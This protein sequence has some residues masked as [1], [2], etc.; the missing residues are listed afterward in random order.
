LLVGL[1]I[2]C[3]FGGG[4]TAQDGVLTT[5]AALN[6]YAAGERDIV[7]QYAP[8]RLPPLWTIADNLG[9]LPKP[10][11]LTATG[12]EE[13]P[14]VVAAFALEAARTLEDQSQANAC[15]LITATRVRWIA[16][17]A[18]SDF[19][20]RWFAAAIASLLRDGCP[21]DLEK[22][23]NVAINVFPTDAS[24]RLARL[25]AAEQRLTAAFDGGERP[26]PREL[27][28]AETRFKI[29]EAL[30]P[31]RAEAGLRW[32][33]INARLGQHA[34]AI[35]FAADAAASPDTRLRYLAHLF[36]GW[37]LAALGKLADADTEYAKAL[38]LVPGAQSATLARAAA[39]FRKRDAGRAD[40]IVSALISHRDPPADP[41]WTYAIGDGRNVDQLIADLRRVIR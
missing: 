1:S 30:P 9:H 3:T 17:D 5:A 33:R 14:R 18:K 2:L 31:S 10:I 12:F 28:D 24:F 20:R 7:A 8:D 22:T 19:D 41:W 32:S 13:S 35:E 15:S 16:G 27:R 40:E 34:Q 4:V 36:R 21:D 23:V 39:A 11:R 26:S 6:R 25:V 29:A 37:S 38:A